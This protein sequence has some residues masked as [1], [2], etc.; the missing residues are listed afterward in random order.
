MELQC[1]HCGAQV[2]IENYTEFTKCSFCGAALYVELSKGIIHYSMN[3]QIEAASLPLLINRF[4]SQIEINSKV[5]Q[6]KTQL[7]Y[8]PYWSFQSNTG[9]TRLLAAS[10]CAIDQMEIIDAPA[11]NKKFFSQPDNSGQ[12]S[13]GLAVFKPVPVTVP[14]KEATLRA[15]MN[16]IFWNKDDPAAVSLVHLPVFETEYQCKGQRFFAVIDAVTGV[17]FADEW[18]PVLQKKKGLVLGA[19][20][21]AAFAVFCLQAFYLSTIWLLI[22]FSITALLL[23]YLTLAMLK[24]L[25]W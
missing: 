8:V 12:G 2:P 6:L 3:P 1:S 24:K 19:V 17:V 25:G 18:P 14:I 22:A 4:L 11:G 23:F 15:P 13:A 7:K 20:A 10:I 5:D 9:K 16:N 21:T